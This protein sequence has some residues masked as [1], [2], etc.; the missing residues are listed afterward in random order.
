MHGFHNY[1]VRT[2]HKH[3]MPGY[4]LLTSKF[5]LTLC[6]WFSLKCTCGAGGEGNQR[7]SSGLFPKAGGADG[8]LWDSRTWGNHWQSYIL[9]LVPQG[10]GFHVQTTSLQRTDTQRIQT[11]AKKRTSPQRERFHN[12]FVFIKPR[13]RDRALKKARSFC[14]A[15][16][17]LLL[18][19]KRAAG[20]LPCLE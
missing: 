10:C 7:W 18:N 15:M 11:Q 19:R 12:N 14:K 6:R 3:N 16:Y 17:S 1:T 20:L 5:P 4:T 8:I 2:S 13:D 9:N